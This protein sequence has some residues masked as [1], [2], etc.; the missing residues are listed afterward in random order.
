MK[1][2]ILFAAM[3]AAAVVSCQKSD[4]PSEKTETKGIPMSLT[5]DFAETKLSYTPDGNV[6]KSSWDAT[7][8]ISVLTFDGS[9]K[10][11]TVD[12]FTS[13]GVAGRTKAE[14]TGTF[15]GGAS[16]TNVI[17]V[18]PALVDNGA[19][20]YETMPYT[21]H[22]G[23]AQSY[24]HSGAIGSEYIQSRIYTLKQTSN[25]DASHLANF[26]ISTGSVNLANIKSNSLSV[27]LQNMM[28]VLKV[29]ATMPAATK[30]KTLSQLVIKPY[31][32][33]GTPLTFSDGLMGRSSSWEY[34]DLVYGGLAAPGSGWQ[35]SATLFA[36]FEVPESGE[37]VFYLANPRY[38]DRKAG[39]KWGF[40][41]FY[42]DGSEQSTGEVFKTFPKNVDFE[43]GRVYRMNVSF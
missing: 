31:D 32:N 23:S 16:A 4:L 29:I 40:E 6:L 25:N 10:L 36:N 24:L 28:M 8:T 35:D 15:T 17:A 21:D 41:V 38:A 30:G 13:T 33:A 14:F 5:A 26:C 12:N 3:A 39:E 2:M 18:Y 34:A 9:G 27:S 7:E 20:K 37:V 22:T 19:G 1:K 43:R 42:W 11:A